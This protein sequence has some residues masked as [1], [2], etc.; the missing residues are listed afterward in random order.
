MEQQ[1][2]ELERRVWQRISGG[3]VKSLK[4]VG[5]LLLD[6]VVWV[7]VNLPYLV[8]FAIIAA[9]VIILIRRLRR[10]KPVKKAPGKDTSP[11]EEPEK[12]DL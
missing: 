6:T 4:G 8:I 10:K 1:D 7:I 12:K 11:K 3:F 5:E 2:L 9:A